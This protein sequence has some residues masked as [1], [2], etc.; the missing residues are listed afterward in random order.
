MKFKLLSLALGALFAGPFAL[1]VS[2]DD[3]DNAASSDA[4]PYES[5]A[6]VPRAEGIELAFE[7]SLQG[8]QFTASSPNNSSLNTVILVALAGDVELLN[9]SIEVDGRVSGVEVADIDANGFPEI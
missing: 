1:V 6:R 3:S 2:A 9:E 5:V 4:A 8:V 7:Q